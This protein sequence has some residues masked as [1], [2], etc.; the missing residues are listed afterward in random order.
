MV[1]IFNS[2]TRGI[3]YMNFFHRRTLI[4]L[5]LICVGASLAGCATHNAQD[6]IQSP[7]GFFSGLWHGAIATL[8][9]TVNITSWLFSLFGIDFLKDVQIIGRP[10]TGFFYYLGFFFG[11]GWLPL[12]R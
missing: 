8:T 3:N 6:V 2:D 10:N 9:I 7:Y 5:A 11:F 12:I 1:K 4:V